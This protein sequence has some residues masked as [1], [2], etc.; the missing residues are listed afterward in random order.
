[1]GPIDEMTNKEAAEVLRDLIDK[2]AKIPIPR[3]NSKPSMTY[4]MLT[5]IAALSKAVDLLEK[6]LD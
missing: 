6:T 2:F 1:M 4:A 3:G 5:N